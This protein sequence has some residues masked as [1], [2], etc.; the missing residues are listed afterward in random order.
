[1][2][3]TKLLV[4]GA[5][6]NELADAGSASFRQTYQSCR[7]LTLAVV[8]LLDHLVGAGEEPSRYLDAERF[9][10]L[11]FERQLEFRGLLDR[12]ILGRSTLQNLLAGAIVSSSRA[13]R[14]NYAFGR[15]A[16]GSEG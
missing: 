2:P 13:R 6:R 4:H 7:L 14:S 3:L 8:A 15:A 1:M 16:N 11:E 10:G 5:N 9:R 12:Q